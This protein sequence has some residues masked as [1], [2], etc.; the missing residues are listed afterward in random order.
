MRSSFSQAVEM[1]TDPKT[2]G[3][4]LLGSLALGVLGNAVFLVFCNMLGTSTLSAV[5]IAFTA[6]AILVFAVV[7]VYAR[8]RQQAAM[9]G[10]PEFRTPRSRR[11]L[12]SWS[13][14]KSR[15]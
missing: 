1:F 2:I 12:I 15:V 14:K 13:R 8:I 11:G 5:G 3:P 10:P 4:F 6:A 9:V 7:L